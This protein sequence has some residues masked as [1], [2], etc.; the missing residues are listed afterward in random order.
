MPHKIP[1]DEDVLAAIQRVILRFGTINSQR[2]LKDVVQQELGNIDP[3]YH[4]AGARVRSLALKSK[5]IRCEIK[6]RH[7][8]NHK[9]KLKRCPVCNSSLQKI[10]NKTLSDKIIT[11]GYKCTNCPYNTDLPIKVPARYIFSARKV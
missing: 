10:R 1:R 2:Q 4:V 8:P 7:W 5:F 6:Y 9:T 3:L 11:I